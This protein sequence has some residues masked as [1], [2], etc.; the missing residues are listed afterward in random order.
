MKTLHYFAIIALFISA[1]A[2]AERTWEEPAS[3]PPVKASTDNIDPSDVQC[4]A[5]NPSTALPIETAYL[6]VK[7]T[8]GKRESSE[9]SILPFRHRHR[10]PSAEKQLCR[11]LCF[12]HPNGY[13][14]YERQL[15]CASLPVRRNSSQFI[16]I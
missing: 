12:R 16:N 9:D 10:I 2:F 5:G 1:G 6:L 13:R 14:R 15:L 11:R 7:F 4:W 8:D 3:Q